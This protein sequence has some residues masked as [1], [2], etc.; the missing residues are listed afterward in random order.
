VSDSFHNVA[1][2]LLLAPA[3]LTDLWLGAMAT[4]GILVHEMVQEISE[5]FVLR[6]AGYSIRGALTRN[7]FV[8]STILIGAI[9]GFYL[10]SIN[11]LIGIL[12]GVAAGGFFYVVVIDLLPHSF[13]QANTIR[14]TGKFILA[15]LLGV[16]LILSLTL[17]RPHMHTNEHASNTTTHTATTS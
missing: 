8:S 10:A 9:S 4:I 11:I 2:G 14:G 15:A 17:I 13:V 16:A 7:F 5:F 6:E 1:D 12:L 3:F